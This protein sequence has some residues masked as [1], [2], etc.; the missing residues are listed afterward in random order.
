[1]TRL[2]PV[3][4]FVVITVC[5]PASAIAV[6]RPNIVVILADDFGVGDIQAHYPDNKIPTPYLDRLVHQGMSFT[7]A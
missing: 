7:D 2:I 6:E 1:M 4:L 3:F 5:P